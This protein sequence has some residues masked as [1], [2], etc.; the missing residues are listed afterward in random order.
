MGQSPAA[1]APHASCQSATDDIL[2]LGPARSAVC[3]MKRMRV[4]AEATWEM[5]IGRRDQST[6]RPTVDKP[7]Q[8][9]NA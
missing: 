8:T 4:P 7:S 3:N 1:G 5:S 9:P 6:D 2:L